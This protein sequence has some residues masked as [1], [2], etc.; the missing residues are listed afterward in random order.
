MRTRSRFKVKVIGSK[1]MEISLGP[2]QE[3]VREWNEGGGPWSHEMDMGVQAE[4]GLGAPDLQLRLEREVSALGLTG[5]AAL[6]RS[7]SIGLSHDRWDPQ[8]QK[9]PLG[10]L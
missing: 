8:C 6:Y 10:H 9:P 4:E 3:L 7:P 5:T 1:T 2:H